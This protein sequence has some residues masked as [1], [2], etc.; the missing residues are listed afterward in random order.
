MLNKDRNNESR[1]LDAVTPIYSISRAS[2]LS[3]GKGTK[4]FLVQRYYRNSLLFFFR[5]VV[6]LGTNA[7]ASV[8]KHSWI[9]D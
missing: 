5:V 4:F 8:L 7:L 2:Q 6:Y 3:I 1:D 9:L